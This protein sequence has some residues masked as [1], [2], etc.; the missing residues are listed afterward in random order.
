MEESEKTKRPLTFDVWDMSH[1]R[2]NLFHYGPL[3]L[4]KGS[5]SK[6]IAIKS[7]TMR[8]QKI[9]YKIEKSINAK[10]PH[11]IRK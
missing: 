1:G 8:T 5:V 7:A 6:L 4:M 10:Y 9:N 2:V 11:L 3:P